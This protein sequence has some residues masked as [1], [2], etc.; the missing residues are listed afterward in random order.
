MK[1]LKGFTIAAIVVLS[2]LMAGLSA[3]S[4]GSTLIEQY[5]EQLRQ[6]EMELR[7]KYDI[8]DRMFARCA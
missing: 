5:N 4:S 3:L 8:V 7:N 6:H 1:F 2:I